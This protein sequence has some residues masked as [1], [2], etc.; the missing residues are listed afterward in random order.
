MRS[1]GDDENFREKMGRR[2]RVE[3]Q[4]PE[5]QHLAAQTG[6]VAWVDR[7]AAPAK[8]EPGPLFHCVHIVI[9]NTEE[10]T[11]EL[12]REVTSR[13]VLFRII[14]EAHGRLHSGSRT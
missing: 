3:V 9:P 6:E 4:F 2:V 11:L 12:R 5:S 7:N 1:L 14:S 8:D 13:V 10:L